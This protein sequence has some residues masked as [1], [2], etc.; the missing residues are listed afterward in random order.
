LVRPERAGAL[1]ETSSVTADQVD[2]NPAN[3]TATIASVAA[4]APS[5][6]GPGGPGGTNVGATGAGGSAL[7]GRTFTIDAHGYVTVRISCPAIAV[8]GC[9]DALAIYSGSGTMPAAVARATRKATLLAIAHTTLK[10][11]RTA[12][13]RLRLNQA[14]R[15][16]AKAHQRFPARV[17]LSAHG[18]PGQQVTSHKYRVTLKR[19]T[20]HR[21]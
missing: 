10:A 7:I 18:A 8:G 14:G 19:A 17:L 9:H 15:R 6:G 11:G 21:R 12:S 16:L 4:L 1:S 2:Y 3:D 20:K 5:T 13:V